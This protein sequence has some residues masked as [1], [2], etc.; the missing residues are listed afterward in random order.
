MKM[1]ETQAKEANELLQKVTGLVNDGQ[2][3]L[4]KYPNK[5][6]RTS[7]ARFCIDYLIT[8]NHIDPNILKIPFSDCN[9]GDY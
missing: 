8:C 3:L 2:L 9:V 4:D 6:V 7:I 1:T 5:E